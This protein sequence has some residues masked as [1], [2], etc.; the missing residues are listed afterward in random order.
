MTIYGNIM[1]QRGKYKMSNK[2]KNQTEQI[3]AK[4]K[5]NLHIFFDNH[6]FAM[7]V[8]ASLVATVIP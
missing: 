5:S 4:E 3:E 1:Y 8:L 2:T 6:Q 7:G